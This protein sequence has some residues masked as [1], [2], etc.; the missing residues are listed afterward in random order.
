MI[1]FVRGKV[2]EKTLTYAVIDVSGVGYACGISSTTSQDLPAPGSDEEYRLF[3]YLQVREDGVSLYG[4]SSME[5]KTTFEKL[6]GLPGVGPKLA[7]SVLSSFTPQELAEVVTSGDER[8]MTTVPGVGK[9]M[10]SRIILELKDTFSAMG[11]VVS[12]GLFETTASSSVADARSA[13]L[14]LGFSPDECDL[15]LKGYDGPDTVENMVKYALKRLG[16]MG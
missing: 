4:F 16:S 6:I 10:A 8:R 12:T 11:A 1:A 7:L 3:T 14:S 2:V 5:E 15:A 9:K 13:L